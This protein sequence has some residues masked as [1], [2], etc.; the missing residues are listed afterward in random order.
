[1][2]RN[3][4]IVT[5]PQT[6]FRPA[7]ARAAGLSFTMHR[8]GYA[9]AMP[10]PVKGTFLGKKNKDVRYFL[11]QSWEGLIARECIL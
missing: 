9:E 11:Y 2:L 6:A 4:L 1:M 7:L 10:K 3:S 8:R 5:L